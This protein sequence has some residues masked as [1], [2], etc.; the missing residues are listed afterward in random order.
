M[1]STSSDFNGLPERLSFWS[2]QKEEREVPLSVGIKLLARLRSSSSTKES[3]FCRERER[4][5]V[6]IIIH[7]NIPQFS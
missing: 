7:L 1:Y 2:L 4:E 6:V 3:I 5:K